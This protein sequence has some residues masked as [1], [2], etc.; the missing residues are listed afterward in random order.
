M[1]KID[2][3]FCQLWNEEH[4]KAELQW[5]DN[6]KHFRYCH[7]IG[8]RVWILRNTNPGKMETWW[9]GPCK[10]TNR[11]DNYSYQVEVEPGVY[12]DVHWDFMK[13]YEGDPFSHTTVPLYYYK[14]HTT[15]SLI[16]GD[17]DMVEAITNHK[18]VAGEQYRYL[19][20]W[21]HSNYPTWEPPASFFQGCCVKFLEYLFKSATGLALIEM[22]FWKGIEPIES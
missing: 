16:D 19:T 17:Y 7:V 11:W 8:K 15:H 2:E 9:I 1:N 12:Q 10:V 14:G 3:T 5:Q 4:K 6:F 18:E 20:K 13:P 22:Q 21:K